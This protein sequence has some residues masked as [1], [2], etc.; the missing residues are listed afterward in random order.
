MFRIDVPSAT[1]DN[2]FT[3]GSPTAGV[4]A[5]IVTADWLNSIQEELMSVLSAASVAPVKGLNTQVLTSIYLLMTGTGGVGINDYV[6]IPFRDKTSGVRREI[7]IQWGLTN[8]TDA[9]GLSTTT[10]PIVFPNSQLSA[11][12][13]KQAGSRQNIVSELAS[14]DTTSI[15]WFASVGSTGA[16]ISG[17]TAKYISLGF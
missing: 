15:Q 5:T 14:L 13:I 3:E 9:S 17:V 11:V 2:K 6:K 12:I 7:I 16:P 10:L 4:Q 1:V 8:G